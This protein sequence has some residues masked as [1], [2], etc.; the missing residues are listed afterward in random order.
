MPGVRLAGLAL[1]RIVPGKA[2]SVE[3]TDSHDPP[4]VVVA[5]V[6]KGTFEVVLLS[7]TFC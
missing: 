2:V 4:E 3:D 6:V 1:M 7:T 5:V